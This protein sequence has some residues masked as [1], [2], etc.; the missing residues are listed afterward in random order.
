MSGQDF[1]INDASDTSDI[2]TTSPNSNNM[3]MNMMLL[4]MKMAMKNKSDETSSSEN[5]FTNIF[6]DY[7]K[8]MSKDR[9]NHKE[10]PQNI[11]RTKE[12]EKFSN[13]S[14]SSKSSSSDSE[15]W[16]NDSSKIVSPAST[17]GFALNLL[18]K[19]NEIN[20]STDEQNQKQ[21]QLNK[22]NN[23]TTTN[24]SNEA[25]IRSNDNPFQTNASSISA[26]LSPSIFFPNTSSMFNISKRKGGQ[27]RFSNEQTIDLEKKFETHKYLS[28]SERK[29]IA[30][31]L[32]LTERQVKTWFQNRRAKWRRLKQE[33]G[34]TDFD[35]SRE[36]L[37]RQYTDDMEELNIDGS[38]E[39]KHKLDINYE[40]T[41]QKYAKY[42]CN[43]YTKQYMMKSFEEEDDNDE[44]STSAPITEHPRKD[45]GDGMKNNKNF[46]ISS[47][48]DIAK[49]NVAFN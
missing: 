44:S 45:D 34:E 28:P 8:N 37:K 39:K 21:L 13:L 23:K 17:N 16:S 48:I 46:S 49:V 25:S 10:H 41:Y 3:L 26:Y 43:Q 18:N 24:H 31:S 27:V 6:D 11:I 1:G 5:N 40:N 36:I 15:N 22:N 38:N 32:N 47:I 30:R 2:S 20:S 42:H 35:D 7:F 12:T 9:N 19:I 14:S 4:T 33:N 29:K